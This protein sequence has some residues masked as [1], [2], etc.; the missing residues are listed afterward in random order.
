M[1]PPGSTKIIKPP[2]PQNLLPKKYSNK[3]PPLRLHNQVDFSL[4]LM[5]INSTHQFSSNHVRRRNSN[6]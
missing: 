6:R 3:R 4:E 5:L 2:K 1:H